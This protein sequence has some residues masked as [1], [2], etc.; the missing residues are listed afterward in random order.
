MEKNITAIYKSRTDGD[1]DF[2]AMVDS[3][4]TPFSASIIAL[5][6]SV[7]E[8]THDTWLEVYLEEPDAVSV[9]STKIE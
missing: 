5:I 8:I 2:V 4:N 7:I 6:K 1:W 3:E 9:Y